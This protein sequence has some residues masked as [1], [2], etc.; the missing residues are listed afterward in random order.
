VSSDPSYHPPL[1]HPMPL[2]L[3]IVSYQQAMSPP[4]Y[5]VVAEDISDLQE[6]RAMIAMAYAGGSELVG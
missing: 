1:P 5:P 2:S 6:G 3:G 4:R